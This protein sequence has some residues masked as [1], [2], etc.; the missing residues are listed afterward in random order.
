[1]TID[2][3]TLFAGMLFGSIGMGYII[4]GKKQQNFIA[5]LSGVALCGI[6]YFVANVLLLVL[7]CG[8]LMAIPFFIGS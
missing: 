8:A 4:Y 6:P 2:T 1:M 3:N 7:I 5:L